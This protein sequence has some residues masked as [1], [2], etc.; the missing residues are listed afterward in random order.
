M[1]KMKD[2][3]KTKSTLHYH[4]F[5]LMILSL[6]KYLEFKHQSNLVNNQIE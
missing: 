5:L 2:L 6:K 1:L 3:R 4:I